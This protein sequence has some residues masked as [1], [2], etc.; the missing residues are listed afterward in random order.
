M[1]WAWGL[2]PRIRTLWEQLAVPASA[3][4]GGTGHTVAGR[5][6]AWDWRGFR[7]ELR[8]CLRSQRGASVGCVRIS[9]VST[10]THGCSWAA[11]TPTFWGPHLGVCSAILIGC[12]AP[13]TWKATKAAQAKNH[14][15]HRPAI[16][17]TK[18][19]T[20]K[21]QNNTP[22]PARPLRGFP[23]ARWGGKVGVGDVPPR[24]LRA[25]HPCRPR[26]GPPW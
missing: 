6:W 1:C 5:G 7:G 12:M 25:P 23:W 13:T 21:A 14:T 17:S 20:A 26:E 15:A 9:R 11:W 24:W 4:S 10:G 19:A 2:D 22:P 16:R 8:D 3:A 18:S